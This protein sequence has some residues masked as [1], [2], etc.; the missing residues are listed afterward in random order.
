[1]HYHTNWSSRREQISRGWS[2]DTFGEMYMIFQQTPDVDL[3]NG[4]TLA[5]PLPVE[6]GE[7]TTLRAVN[8][9]HGATNNKLTGHLRVT[10][11]EEAS[12]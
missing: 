1:M 11:I 7:A 2:V 6:G 9:K 3:R 5:Q 12:A 10:V 8:L 4:T